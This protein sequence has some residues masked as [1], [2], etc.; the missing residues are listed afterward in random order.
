MRHRPLCSCQ[1]FPCEQAERERERERGR[2]IAWQFKC[3]HIQSCMCCLCGFDS[4]PKYS[5]EGDKSKDINQI[6][7]QPFTSSCDFLSSSPSLLILSLS[8]SLSR[9]LPPSLP[10]S[11]SI[12]MTVEVISEV[13]NGERKRWL[14][15][16]EPYRRLKDE[17]PIIPF[18][19]GPIISKWGAISRA[20]RTGYHTT[21][22]VQATACQGSNST[23]P[24]DFRDYGPHT[25]HG[26]YRWSSCGS[27]S[28]SHSSFLESDQLGMCELSARE[29]SFGSG[30]KAGAGGLLQTDYCKD[31]TES[32][33]DRDIELELSALDMED[34]D[35]QDNSQHSEES[36]ELRDPHLLTTP[37]SEPQ[38]SQTDKLSAD[39]MEAHL[40][41]K[42]AFRKSL[43]PAGLG[44]GGLSVGK[45]MM[46]T[47]PPRLGDMGPRPNT[48][49]EMLLNG[50]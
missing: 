12:S 3:S 32:E 46:R 18:G 36:L 28:S 27:D 15:T 31:T 24:V 40:L 20:S 7:Y 14:H 50:S 6:Q 47:G 49:P 8:L 44:S 43:S 13:D 1:G 35:L 48:G 10:T 25:G 34:I 22:P 11:P 29:R 42:M 38:R 16:F 4:G 26:D 17:D 19:E 2:G 33:P 30:E 21:D 5:S 39:K 41:K 45:L 9:S 37:S 23:T